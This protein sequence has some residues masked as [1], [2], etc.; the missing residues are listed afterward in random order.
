MLQPSGGTKGRASPEESFEFGN[1]GDQQMEQYEE[2][3]VETYDFGKDGNSENI[4]HKKKKATAG[5][6]MY[7]PELVEELEEVFQS[8]HDQYVAT[9]LGGTSKGVVAKAG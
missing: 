9:F 8:A 5:N 4:R 7:D 1:E 3:K 2:L 6:K